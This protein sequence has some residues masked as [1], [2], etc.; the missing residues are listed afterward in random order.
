V[1]YKGDS[2]PCH[3]ISAAGGFPHV[4]YQPN[5]GDKALINR[6]IEQLGPMTNA[7]RKVAVVFGATALLWITRPL[8]SD[9]VPGLSGA[10]V[11]MTAGLVLLLR[12]HAH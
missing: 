11:A 5:P 9:L 12:A 8:L 2:H 3:C 4:G 7:E 1:D 10:G 6:Q